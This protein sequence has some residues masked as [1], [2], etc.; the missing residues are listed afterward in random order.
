MA[1]LS[2][3]KIVKLQCLIDSYLL[4]FFN[5]IPNQKI[6][7]HFFSTAMRNAYGRA[8]SSEL[9]PMIAGNITGIFHTPL[10]PS[11]WHTFSYFEFPAVVSRPSRTLCVSHFFF[12][13]F[14]GR[15]F[16]STELALSR[17]FATIPH[18][19]AYGNEHTRT[20]FLSTFLRIL[21]RF[22]HFRPDRMQL[23]E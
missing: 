6:E 5:Y 22:C 11:I 17:Y 19:N 9:A 20:I 2:F 12:D 8:V 13:L 21:F 4:P 7:C 10:L 16:R 14:F 1:S 23:G 3:N 15:A 18:S